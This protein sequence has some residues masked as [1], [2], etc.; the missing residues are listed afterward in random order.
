MYK[1]KISSSTSN[2]VPKTFKIVPICSTRKSAISDSPE[3]NQSMV[4]LPPTF[5][6]PDDPINA[7]LTTLRQCAL[8]YRLHSPT[9]GHISHTILDIWTKLHPCWQ[10][11][12]SFQKSCLKIEMQRIKSWFQQPDIKEFLEVFDRRRY[13]GQKCFNSLAK[14]GISEQELTDFFGF[15][16]A[17]SGVTL[18]LLASFIEIGKSHQP[19]T[20][21]FESFEKTQALA[22]AITQAE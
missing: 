12:E 20:W 11:V 9:N 19:T 21:T 13:L 14:L 22:P 17:H 6:P 1:G 5:D 4:L 10:V 16:I 7:A 2:L 15:G 18:K 3:R 8:D